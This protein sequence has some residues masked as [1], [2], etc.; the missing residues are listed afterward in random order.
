MLWKASYFVKKWHIEQNMHYFLNQ[1][2]KI[3]KKS[4]GFHSANVMQDRAL[5]SSGELHAQEG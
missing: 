5:M 3:S 4:I 1:H 2:L